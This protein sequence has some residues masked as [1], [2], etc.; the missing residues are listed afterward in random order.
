MLVCFRA[1]FGVDESGIS[2]VRNS[3]VNDAYFRPEMVRVGVL[4]RDIVSHAV[5]LH[6][7]VYVGNAV[8][9]VAGVTAVGTHPS[10]RRRGFGSATVQDA[11]RLVRRS[12]YHLA[13][14]TTSVA[15]FFARF[16]FQEVP[17]IDGYECPAAALAEL[18]VDERYLIQRFEYHEHWPALAS[19]YQQYSQGRTGMQVRDIRFWDTWPRRGTFPYGFSSQADAIGLM[20]QFQGQPIAYLAA[21]CP[22]EQRHL[23]V[24]EV[25]HLRGHE[26][27]GL[28]L[29]REAADRFLAVGSG[30]AVIRLSG[31]APVLGLLKERSVPLEVE[32]GP[33]LMV[34]IPETSWLRSVG[35]RDAQEA[36]DHLFRSPPPTVWHRDGY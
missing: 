20:A 1:A 4:D 6:R 3:L 28:G 11:L 27:A 31:N 14:L 15:G 10:Y 25:A 32:V 16:G 35:L 30:R 2:I 26:E 22:A 13:M 36:V 8:I 19:I 12:G 21:H 29:L 33:G 7:S 9:N 23:S 34:L 24:S 18:P 17:K 5:V